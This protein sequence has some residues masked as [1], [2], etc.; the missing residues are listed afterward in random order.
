MAWFRAAGPVEYGMLF[1]F[2]CVGIDR[3]DI[4]RERRQ[5]VETGQRNY[6]KF[7]IDVVAVFDHFGGRRCQDVRTAV[8]VAANAWVRAE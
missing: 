4:R 3:E 2:S 8:P 5:L 7:Y 6:A 1:G